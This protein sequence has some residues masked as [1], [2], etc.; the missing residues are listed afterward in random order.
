VS[1]AWARSSLGRQE[2][3]QAGKR[4][5]SRQSL[6]FR[7]LVPQ[8]PKLERRDVLVADTPR[9]YSLASPAGTAAGIV[10]CLHGRGTWPDWQAWISGMD[11][12]ARDEDAVVVFPRGSVPTDR[13]GCSW[14]HEADLL[15]LTAR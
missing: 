10:L 7:P 14:D 12:L 5:T 2:Q 15:Y 1:T 6:V 13:R 9:E 4:F 3:P 11:R 8:L